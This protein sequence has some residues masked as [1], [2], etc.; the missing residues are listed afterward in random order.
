MSYIVV[1][2]PPSR[3]Y[4]MTGK[5]HEQLGAKFEPGSPEFEHAFDAEMESQRQRV[6][7]RLF[8]ELPKS[9]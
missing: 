7:N 2:S 3:L 6:T 4:E 1:G 8:I 9:R 5:I